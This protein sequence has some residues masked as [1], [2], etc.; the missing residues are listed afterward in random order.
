MSERNKEEVNVRKAMYPKGTRVRL[1]FMD[2]IQAPPSGTEGTVEYVDDI[3]T[4]H[5]HWDN[6]S[7]LGLAMGADQCELI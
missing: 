1:I 7:G 4:I 3:G 2:D 5:V 6:G